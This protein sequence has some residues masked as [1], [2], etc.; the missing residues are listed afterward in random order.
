[1]RVNGGSCFAA[2]DYSSHDTHTQDSK[3][4]KHMKTREKFSER[5]S[6][7][8]SEIASIRIVLPVVELYQAS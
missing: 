4:S 2:V 3:S 8:F 6:E 5:T 1:M 7:Y